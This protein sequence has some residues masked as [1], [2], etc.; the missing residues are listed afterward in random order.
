MKVSGLDLNLK[1]IIKIILGFLF[2]PIYFFSFLSPRSKKIWVFGDWNGKQFSDNSKYFFLYIANNKKNILR[3]I[4]ISKDKDI[5]KK[6]REKGY[7]A[8]CNLSLKGIYYP[9]RAKYFIIDVHSSAINYW[10]S[11]GAEKINLW[12]GMPLKKIAFDAVKGEGSDFYK[13]RGIKKFIYKIIIPWW[14]EKYDIVITTSEFFQKIFTSA[15]KINKNE[16]IIAGQPRDDI[17]FTKFRD[18]NFGLDKEII[19]KIENL[20]NENAKLIFYLPT[21]RDLGGDPLKDAGFDFGKLQ[22][23]L[24]LNKAF[25]IIK[26]HLYTK[27]DK[28]SF[29]VLSSKEF[30]ILPPKIDIFPLLPYINILIT[31]YSSIYS[32]FLLLNKPIIFFPYD[33]Q[34]Y[35]SK[36]RELYVDYEQFTPGPKAHKFKELLEWLEYFLNGND[37]FIRD[38]ERIKNICFKYIDGQSSER[39]FQLITKGVV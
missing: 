24:S 33:F 1:N 10:L 27:I 6:L 2:R 28:K 34:D 9:L 15:F 17:F 30:I 25:F 22:K 32:D 12:H 8:Y 35:I 39:I 19:Q 7:E 21:F 5:V 26:P 3:A 29:E 31:D 23:F 13:S 4:W 16:V 18:S 38:R 20:K 14:F 36:N 37:E 11:G